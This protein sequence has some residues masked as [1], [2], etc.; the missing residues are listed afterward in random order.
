VLF[1]LHKSYNL[2]MKNSIKVIILTA[3]SLLILSSVLLGILNVVDV[4]TFEESVDLFIKIFY[5]ILIT[6]VGFSL[7]AFLTSLFKK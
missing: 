7:I 4:Y 1:L 3:V 6:G 5:I 2:F